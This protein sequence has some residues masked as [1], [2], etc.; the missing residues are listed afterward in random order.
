MNSKIAILKTMISKPHFINLR[1]GLIFGYFLLFSF[2]V[3]AQ[4]NT[5]LF[6][7]GNQFYKSQNYQEAIDQWKQIIENGEASPELYF[8]LGNAYYKLNKVGPA[9]YYY[10]KAKKLAPSNAS[11]NNNLTFAKNARVDVIEPLPDTL[12]HKLYKTISGM[13]SHKGWAIASI[14]FSVSFSVL[15]LLYYFSFSEHKKRLFFITALLSLFFLL[16]S[17][18]LAFMTHL[19]IKNDKAAIVF[20]TSTQVKTEPNMNSETGFTLHEGTKV[21]VLEELDNWTHIMLENGKEGWIISQ[22]IKKL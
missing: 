6:E 11:I 9:I 12:L 4:N 22:D 18:T 7:K 21:H 13:L 15:F 20:A 5:D 16:G 19:D 14:V 3:L 1:K 8:N 17:L 2:L 10:E